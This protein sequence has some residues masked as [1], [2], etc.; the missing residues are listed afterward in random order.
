MV[1]QSSVFQVLWVLEVGTRCIDDGPGWKWA[2]AR[3]RGHEG[4][5]RRRKWATA[6]SLCPTNQAKA[7]L[8]VVCVGKLS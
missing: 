1:R 6:R 2:M 4:S 8:R 5:G 3:G 7:V